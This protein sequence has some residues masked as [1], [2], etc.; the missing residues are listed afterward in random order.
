MLAAARPR[1]GGRHTCLHCQVL[2]LYDSFLPCTG[3]STLKINWL[4]AYILIVKSLQPLETAYHP[5]L[6]EYQEIISTC[7][8]QQKRVSFLDK[9]TFVFDSTIVIPV[10]FTAM[11][12]RVRKVCYSAIALLRTF[13]QRGVVWDSHVAAEIGA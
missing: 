6:L 8:L 12:V 9:T 7:I 3:V 2:G 10:L 1:D 4:F 13:K 5:M 11:N